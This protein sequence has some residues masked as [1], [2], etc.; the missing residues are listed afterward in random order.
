MFKIV[1]RISYAILGGVTPTSD[2]R[3]QR[4]QGILDHRNPGRESLW[5]SCFPL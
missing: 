3:E 5:D 4:I 2:L 1:K